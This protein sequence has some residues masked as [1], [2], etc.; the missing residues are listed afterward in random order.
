MINVYKFI[1]DGKFQLSGIETSFSTK[2]NYDFIQSEVSFNVIDNT[3]IEPFIETNK[4]FFIEEYISVKPIYF[5]V[6][7]RNIKKYSL[8]NEI[9]KEIVFYIKDKGELPNC[10][11]NGGTIK[12]INFVVQ[13]GHYVEIDLSFID[14]STT[15]ESVS[16]LPDGLI[17]S[18]GK[19]KGTPILAGDFDFTIGVSD[20]SEILCSINIPNLI[21]LL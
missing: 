20:K 17:F 18:N 8:D 13:K 16:G 11:K 14:T 19:I 6:K 2:I 4:Q 7:D 9:T 5:H 10:D 21:R 12:G 15:I 1:G 3:R